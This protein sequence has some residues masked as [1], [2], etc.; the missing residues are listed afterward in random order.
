MRAFL[1]LAAAALFGAPSFAQRPDRN[2]YD[3]GFR[4]G[5]KE[6]YSKG[7]IEGVAEGQR[8]AGPPA[9]A[10]PPKPGPD[11]PIR[12]QSAFYGTSS[13]NCN[14]THWLALRADGRRSHSVEIE[15]KICGDPAP[16]QRKS[17]EV[18][19]RCGTFPKAASAFEH[20]TLYLDCN[21]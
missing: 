14:A 7:Y 8:R 19:Y 4:A 17:M 21:D 6:G 2:D 10:P 9:V 11:G 20:R 5:F 3:E 13:K 1:V 12:I 18:T 16:G 15:N